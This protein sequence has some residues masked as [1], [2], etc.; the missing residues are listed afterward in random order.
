MADLL[1]VR[2]RVQTIEHLAGMAEQLN[3]AAVWLARADADAPAELVEQAAEKIA[4]ALWILEAPV[5][6]REPGMLAYQTL[7]AANGRHS[8]G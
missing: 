2:Q 1:S 5:R 6:A 3:Q 8:G 4:A 7:D